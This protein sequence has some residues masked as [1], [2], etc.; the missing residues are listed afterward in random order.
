MTTLA[1]CP[2]CDDLFGPLVNTLLTHLRDAHGKVVEGYDA[3]T[4]NVK[5][6]GWFPGTIEFVEVAA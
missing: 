6:Q 4:G 3:S 1:R 2:L 5:L